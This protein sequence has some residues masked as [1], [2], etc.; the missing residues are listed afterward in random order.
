MSIGSHLKQQW[1][2]LLVGAAGIA[3]SIYFYQQSREERD[4]VFIVDPNR[5]E[6]VSAEHVAT[7]PIKVLRRDNSPIR[8]D[9]Y[10]VRFFFWNAGRRSIRPENVLEPIR[11]T[12]G[13]TSSEILDFKTL[14]DSRSVARLQL[15]RVTTDPRS[16][17]VAFSILERD[18]GVA[19]QVIYQG[20]RDAPLRV[21][22]TIEGA[23]I[24]TTVAPSPLMAIVEVAGGTV[25]LIGA[26]AGVFFLI[27]VLETK[28]FVKV[29]FTKALAL[30][31]FLVLVGIVGSFFVAAYLGIRQE[32]ATNVVSFVPPSLVR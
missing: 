12:L 19:G 26:L 10:A 16:L 28:V 7:A 27:H 20:R 29:R 9:V 18:D 3:L 2:G 32:G 24:R 23:A 15:T 14:K 11:M 22:G 30:G 25:L 31:L 6:I 8:A 13:D 5:V 4:P 17:L 1:L 21:S